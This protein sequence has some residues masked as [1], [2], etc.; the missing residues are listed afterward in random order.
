MSSSNLPSELSTEQNSAACNKEEAKGI[1]ADLPQWTDSFIQK[2]VDSRAALIEQE[3]YTHISTTFSATLTPMAMEACAIVSRIRTAERQSVWNDKCNS[4]GPVFPGMPFTLA[5]ERMDKSLLLKVMRKMPKGA[6]LHAHF[7]AM[8]DVTWLIGQTLATEGM[9]F[10]SDE[11]LGSERSRT[12]ASIS[13][14]YVGA[15][16]SEDEADSIWTDDYVPKT[17]VT[18]LKAADSFPCNGS[19]GFVDWLV[20][21]CTIIPT[22]SLDQH[23]GP[24]TIWGK[25]ASCFPVINSMLFYE[26][27][28]RL[29]LQRM[30]AELLVDGIRW[31]DL[32]LAFVFQY[33]CTGSSV[34]ETTY[35]AFFRV[36]GDELN[37]FKS[38]NS[39]FWGARF[40][41]TT[42]R[43]F[44]T[45]Q[46]IS[47]MRECIHQK[48]E[49]PA[50]ISGFD[51]VGFEDAGRTLL[52]LTPELVW[53]RKACR[54]AGVKIPFFFH[55]GECLGHDD[56]TDQNM[57][58]AI[59]LG[60]QRIGHGYALFKHPLLI[61]LVKDKNICIEC[62]P[63]SNEILRL[64]A[65][66]M[67]HPLP[68]LL[69]NGVSVV[70]SN[71][72][73]A[74]LGHRANG[75]TDDFCQ[76]IQAWKGLGLE[77]LAAMAENSVRFAAFEGTDDLNG[78]WS[79]E[80]K[81]GV[82]GRG[83]RAE[84]MREWR[85]EW[86]LFCEWVVMEYAGDWGSESDDDPPQ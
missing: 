12:K 2:Y 52:S 3:R 41:W 39:S 63:I 11:G 6:L 16:L 8:V 66:I 1:P 15:G 31:V 25:F 68:A 67:Q 53:F 72:D 59:L 23:H 61:Q 4:T 47:S 43:S 9:G 32:R 45:D 49:Y 5:R 60:T 10:V 77:G 21:R 20:T 85:Q 51:L 64:T 13:F 17:I 79:K 38:Q 46:I 37:S 30:F 35:N 76:A 57:F 22:E 26:P 74:I 18:A 14:R 71:D 33:F 62:C 69:A 50:L 54:T 7:D 65:N 42:L 48:L 86:N 70:L 84:R 80:V 55:A 56:D 44:P 81:D 58:D 36:F 24:Y 82:Y 19:A 83:A 78:D 28:F 27:V 29:S 40:I 34:P 73:P 75:L